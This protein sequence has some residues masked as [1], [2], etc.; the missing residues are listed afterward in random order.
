[1]WWKNCCLVEMVVLRAAGHVRDKTDDARNGAEGADGM[2]TAEDLSDNYHGHEMAV[3][4]SEEAPAHGTVVGHL[5]V[6]S[7]H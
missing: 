1:M 4:Q 7:E 6:G 5:V 3:A 2:V